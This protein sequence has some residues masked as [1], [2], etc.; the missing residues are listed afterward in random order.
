MLKQQSDEAFVL[1][2]RELG[3]ADLI[4][5]LIAREHGRVRCVA[6]SARRSR[7]RFGGLLEPLTRIRAVWREREGRD[8]HRLDSAELI[9]SHAAMQA[10]PL[11]L[12]VC[13]TIAEIATAFGAEGQADPD[14]FRLLG[15]VLD[16]LERGGEPVALLRY[17]ELWTLRLH[18][19]FPDL[20]SCA[21]CGGAPG[22][23][24]RVTDDG[25]LHCDGC[26]PGSRHRLDR[27]A[28]EFLTTARRAAPDA[29]EVPPRAARPGGP[30]ERLLRS[31]LER[32]AE[33]RFR[34]YR[35]VAAAAHDLSPPASGEPDHGR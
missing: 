10:D 14:G 26:A 12:A 35:H 11:H 34:G 16:A 4:V 22:R 23:S 18:G 6:P 5:T 7:R 31:S 19:L 32:F 21:A 8:L 29:I 2:T 33:R 13:A 17:Y 24:P 9:E 1:S 28:R 27:T 3:D 15:A 20:E 30:L 25:E